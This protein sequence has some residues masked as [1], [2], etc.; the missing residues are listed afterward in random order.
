GRPLAAFSAN[1]YGVAVGGP[2]LI[3]KVYDGRNK[4]FWFASF[5]GAR[6]GNGQDNILSVPTA[7]MRAGDFSEVAQ[8]IYDPYS[9]AMVNGAPTRTPFAGNVVP[10]NRK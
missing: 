7:K 5:E 2:V 4:T 8:A 10:A 1:T 6:E 9:V 3:P